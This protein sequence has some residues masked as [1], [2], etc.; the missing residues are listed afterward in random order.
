MNDDD[1]FHPRLG[2]IKRPSSANKRYANQVRAAINRAGGRT[3][4]KSK[5]TGSRIGR[6]SVMGAWLVNRH[7]Q[8]GAHHRR[9]IVKARI[10]KLAGKGMERAAAHMRYVQRDGVSREGER[11]QLYGPDQD[12]MEGKSFL[13]RAEGDRHQFRFI[14]AP[15]D[16]SEYDDFR[17]LT[18]RLMARMEKDLGTRLDWVAVD[19]FNTGH[20]HIHIIVRGKDETGHDLVLARNYLTVGIRERAAELVN[21]DLGPRS[22]LEIATQLRADMTAERLTGLDK[23]LRGLEDDQGMVSPLVKDAA[24]Q[25]LLTGRLKHLERLGLAEEQRPGQWCLDND[26]EDTLRRIG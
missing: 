15:E 10:V 21:L 11:G 4:R 14:V 3:G 20:P 2:R 23:Q 25:T 19:H 9:V 17:P 22:E 7:Q 12:R 16:R 5:F 13:D 8:A 24:R 26:L 6:G 1:E 18:R